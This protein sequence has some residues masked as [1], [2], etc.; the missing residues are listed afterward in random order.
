MQDEVGHAAAAAAAATAAWRHRLAGGALAAATAVLL[1]AST[2]APAAAELQTISSQ[3][4]TERARPLPQQAVDKG[5]IWLLFVLGGA[6]L[7]G[8]TVALENN[9]SWFPAISRANKAMRMTRKQQVAAD[10]EEAAAAARLEAVRGEREADTRLE[11]AV[12]AGLAEAKASSPAASAAGLLEAAPTPAAAE[13]EQPAVSSLYADGAVL[14][15][16]HEGS[17]SRLDEAAPSPTPDPAVVEDDLPSPEQRVLFTIT[18]DQIQR[19]TEQQAIAALEAELA[20]RRA[21]AAS[22]G[23]EQP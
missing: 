4:A 13:D 23:S 6:A 12:L 17:S 16:Q 20:K 18:P 21:G 22:S 15:Q 3:E 8:T 9:E 19:S 1:L 5:R 7:F 2:P 14:L 11:S 10:A